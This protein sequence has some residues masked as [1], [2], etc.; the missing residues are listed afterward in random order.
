[1][2][3]L[4]WFSVSVYLVM[5]I[6]GIGLLKKQTIP[7][8]A[9]WHTLLSV[10]MGTFATFLILLHLLPHGIDFFLGYLSI[11]LAALAVIMSLIWLTASSLSKFFRVPAWVV[12]STKFIVVRLSATVAFLAA[13]VFF[14]GFHSFFMSKGLRLK[15]MGSKIED[16]GYLIPTSSLLMFICS[17][18]LVFGGIKLLK[19]GNIPR[20][21]RWHTILSTSVGALN[22]FLF[23]CMIIHG[24]FLRVGI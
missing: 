6:G 18:P 15:P 22:I 19:G 4:G 17:L 5:A 13:F 3:V 2:M 9:R 20:G 11:F 10:G 24:L 23:I 8:S 21:A 12:S 7:P 16:P 1:M 14:V